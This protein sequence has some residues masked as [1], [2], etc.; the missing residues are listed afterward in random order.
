MSESDEARQREAELLAAADGASEHLARRLRDHGAGC[1]CEEC[2]A[3]TR[4]DLAILA[5]RPRTPPA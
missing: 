4:L 2:L 1:L 3:L 5:V